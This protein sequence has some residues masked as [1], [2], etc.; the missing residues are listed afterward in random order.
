M[1]AEVGDETELF[2]D[3]AVIAIALRSIGYERY[4][5]YV[6]RLMKN[7]GLTDEMILMKMYA[8]TRY[9]A[10][11]N[12]KDN[13]EQLF[14][15]LT[16]A[17]VTLKG[18]RKRGI[19][20]IREKARDT[21]VLASLLAYVLTKDDK[22]LN[23]TLDLYRTV[24]WEDEFDFKLD[25]VHNILISVDKPEVVF[26]ILQELEEKK[27]I[28]S[29]FIVLLAPGLSATYLNIG[30]D[31]KLIEYILKRIRDYGTKILFIEKFIENLACE[32]LSRK[33][34]VP[35]GFC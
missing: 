32:Q 14:R 7:K 29:E 18:T 4:K 11:F 28:E 30:K 1:L 25:L 2:M 26:S 27:I 19:R 9:Y 35:V 34:N 23:K 8:L 15:S 24:D 10:T 16:F 17:P 22:Y 13:L 33:F 20:E 5:D 3:T 12:E 6:K 21:M 31:D